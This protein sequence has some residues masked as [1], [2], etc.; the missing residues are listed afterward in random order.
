M[1]ENKTVQTYWEFDPRDYAN[2]FN[3]A[4]R[5]LRQ[6]TKN[7]YGEYPSIDKT[8]I[9]KMPANA[10]LWIYKSEITIPAHIKTHW[11]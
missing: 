5:C 1:R 10:E 2:M 4:V 7:L 8:E 11:E 3:L 9:Y 6:H